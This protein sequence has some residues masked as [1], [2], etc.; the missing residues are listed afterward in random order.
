MQTLRTPPSTVQRLLRRQQQQVE[1]YQDPRVLPIAVL[2]AKPQTLGV[3]GTYEETLINTANQKSGLNEAILDS[4]ACV[5]PE[6]NAARIQ[7][8]L[9]EGAN[10]IANDADAEAQAAQFAGQDIDDILRSRTSRRNIGNKGG[11]SFSVATFR[12]EGGGDRSD[13][14]GGAQGAAFWQ[15]LLPEAVKAHKKAE[16]ERN[17]VHGPRARRRINY[18]EPQPHGDAVRLP[19]LMRH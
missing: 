3:Q 16:A 4:S 12:A 19:L 14:S 18:R 9:R 8:L 15:D 10:S 1:C 7:R 2:C 13:E 5:D 17:L 11:S 6:A